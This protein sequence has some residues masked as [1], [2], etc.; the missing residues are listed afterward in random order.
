M[1]DRSRWRRI[2]AYLIYL[3]RTPLVLGKENTPKM[4]LPCGILAHKKPD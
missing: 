2:A 1:D 4:G 3:K